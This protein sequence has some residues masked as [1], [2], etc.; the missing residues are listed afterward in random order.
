M[1]CAIED[2]AKWKNVILLFNYQ[3]QYKSIYNTWLSIYSLFD[4]K[5]ISNSENQFTPT[6]LLVNSYGSNILG[7]CFGKLSNGIIEEYNDEIKNLEVIEF[8]NMTEFA[9]YAARIFENAEK[10][11]DES[12]KKAPTLAYMSEQMY[13]ASGK[14]NDILRA[15]FPAQFGERHFLDYPIG[16]FF[17]ATINM[18]DSEKECA[19][20]VDFSDIRECLGAGIISESSPGILLSTF[21]KTNAFI[22]KETTLSGIITKL[23]KLNKY[24]GSLQGDKARIGYFNVTK[25][26]LLELINALRE[27]NSIIESF[28]VD[29]NRDGDNFQ[30]FYNHIQKF[31]IN[32]VS[33]LSDIDDEMKVVLE[34]LI[35]RLE[36]SNLPDTGTF[37][38]LKQTMSY[39]LSQDDNLNHG[40]QWIVRGFEQI[41]GDILRSNFQ[42]PTKTLYHF[43]CLSDRDIYS[44]RNAKLPWPLDLQFFEYAHVATEQKYRIFV[45]SKME[46]HNFNRCALLYGLVFNRL[47]CKLSYVKYDGGKENDLFYVFKM[48]GIKVR[49]YKSYENSSYVP[50]LKYKKDN[51]NALKDKLD[52]LSTVDKYKAKLCPYRFVLESIIQE[53]TEFREMFLIHN[54]VKVLIIN[55]IASEKSGDNFN[56]SDLRESIMRVYQEMSDKFKLDDEIEKSKMV[57][58][59]YTYIKSN[60]VVNKKYKLYSD[61]L[62]KK[63]FKLKEDFLWT[64]LKAYNIA[65]VKDYNALI[66]SKGGR[67]NYGAHCKY[68]ASKDICLEHKFYGD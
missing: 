9:N 32:R 36:Q 19:K 54:Y 53:R 42:D 10:Q 58:S 30:R 34:K 24:V 63:V 60:L 14:V 17:V 65:D 13:A 47:A 11:R 1:L 18:W 51:G 6:S 23:K 43:C 5:I 22:E 39:Y 64:D 40:A 21:D 7:D 61:D 29:F 38:C 62:Y 68:C 2:V 31:I 41:D 3:E 8:E 56:D 27:L 44:D 33:N 49:K 26:H 16:H 20:V 25:D 37:T 66:E 35:K 57:A 50:R 15:Y 59:V 55:K 45:K 12:H 67:C 52:N 46:Y 4:K 48:L 28:F